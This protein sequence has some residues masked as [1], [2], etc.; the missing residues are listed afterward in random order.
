MT[1]INGAEMMVLSNH[2]SVGMIASTES[3]P[4]SDSY[5]ISLS[6][7]NGVNED[8]IV[9]VKVLYFGEESFNEVKSLDVPIELNTQVGTVIRQGMYRYE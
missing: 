8:Q 2:L 6:S 4:S 1:I 5:I 7:D 3:F 9:N